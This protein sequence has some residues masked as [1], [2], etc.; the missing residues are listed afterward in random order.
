MTIFEHWQ[1]GDPKWSFF[2]SRQRQARKG[3]KAGKERRKGKDRQG[4]AQ[5]QA[6]KTKIYD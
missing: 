4:K 5:E 1:S 2:F 6:W 3:T